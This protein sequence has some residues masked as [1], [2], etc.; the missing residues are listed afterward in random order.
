MGKGGPF[1]MKWMRRGTALVLAFLLSVAVLAAGGG[2]SLVT[3]SVL[4]KEY[5]DTVSEKA[6]Q[7]AASLEQEANAYLE[8]KTQ[9][10][11]DAL[12]SQAA[13][14]LLD[15]VLAQVGEKGRI[16]ELNKGDTVTG[17][18]GAGFVMR[19][20]TAE[21]TGTE[22]VNVTAG[23]TRP[24]GWE[25]ARN[26]Y[27]MIPQN[28]QSGIRITSDTARV[29]LLDGATTSQD[30]VD[31]YQVQYL[32]YA[33]ALS[34][35]GLFK[36]TDVGF[37]LEREPTRL[38]CLIML[39]RL[40]GEEQ[41]AL[42]YEGSHPFTD[43]TGWQDANRYVAYA[44]HMGYTNGVSA[45]EFA[46]N[47]PCNAATMYTYVLR[48]LGYSDKL[49]DF[50]WNST[51]RVMMVQTGILTQSEMETIQRGIFRRDQAAFVLWRSLSAALKNSDVTLVSK[52]IAAGAVTQA[53]YDQA[54]QNVP[55]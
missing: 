6:R 7:K 30:T 38:E 23:G 45:T 37:E 52:L 54:R 42:S 27:Y 12:L 14:P 41:A 48:A 5:L 40:L 31:G 17:P 36:G 20:G 16:V 47:Q 33:Q 32:A 10:T 53:Q 1:L 19:K 24:G 34:V 29:Q 2:E 8:E 44:V 22:V 49:G 39:I 13:G 15:A 3:L 35:M 25:I 55:S 4:R 11:E 50:V 21:V 9:E 46:P 18:L 43:I 51:D 26:I 28:D